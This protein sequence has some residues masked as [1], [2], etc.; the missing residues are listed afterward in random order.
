MFV[1]P[2]TASESNFVFVPKAD[3]PGNDLLR[4][5]NSSF[6]DCARRCDSWRDCNAF[7]YNQLHNVC[8]L[9]Y[10]ADRVTSFY[11]FAITGIKLS[12]SMPP[13]AGASRSGG[14]SFVIL[15]QADTP[16]NDYSRIDNFSF[17]DCR[18][19]CEADDACNAFTYNHARGVCFLKRAANQWTTFYAW[20]ATGIKLRSPQPGERTATPQHLPTTGEQQTPGSQATTTGTGFMVSNDGFILTNRHV[21]D[22]CGSV[23][24][25]DSGPAI[26]KE[27][28]D[29]NDLALLKIQGSTS[30]ATFRATSPN[31]GESIYALGFPYAGV[32]GAGINF[33]SGNI[34]SLSGIANDT[35]YLQ[36]TAPIQPG[37]SGGPLVDGNGLVV[38]VVS[39]RLADI[40][41]LKASGSLPQNVNFAIQGDLA[42]GFLRANGVQPKVAEPK[43]PLSTSE[44]ANNAKAYTVEIICQ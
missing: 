31:L 7:T 25:H 5:D 32:L 43:N 22:N 20:A 41:I 10:V 28:D 2:A 21:V 24:I 42:R 23:T 8:F 37:N 26:V 11:A 16:G 36:F 38:G 4:V 17:E 34:S 39:A 9:K 35:R 27:V 12:P 15:S 14:P 6:E 29:T 1:A 13:T 44:I 33:T 19:S 30:T 40:E 18:S 3:L